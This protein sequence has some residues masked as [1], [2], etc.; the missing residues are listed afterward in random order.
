MC[1]NYQ[2]WYQTPRKVL[3]VQILKVVTAEMAEAQKPVM[4]AGTIAATAEAAEKAA[5]DNVAKMTAALDVARKNVADRKQAVTSA[6]AAMAKMVAEKTKP[7]EAAL[8]AATDAMTKAQTAHDNTEKDHQARLASLT[9]TV[10]TQTADAKAK[11]TA[12]DQ[13]MP[14]VT[15]ARKRL[16]Q[17]ETEYQKLKSAAASKD[18]PTKT[19]SN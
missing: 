8:T 9:Q 13:F 18:A 11:Q 12:L 7:M 19:A 16:E 14:T 17:L 2:S 15:E 4:T 6:E 3:I 10:A 5:A 1:R